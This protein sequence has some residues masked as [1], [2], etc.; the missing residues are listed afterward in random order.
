GKT[1]GRA[2]FPPPPKDGHISPARAGK[3][4]AEE[5][6]NPR[7]LGVD[8]KGK[9]WVCEDDFS[10]KRV[11]IW[12]AATGKLIEEKFGP[13]YVSTAACMD[14]ADPTRVYCQNVEWKVDLDKG[15]WQPAAIMFEAKS[16]SPYFWPHMVNNIVFTAKNGKQYM[17]AAGIY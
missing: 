5:I 15:T 4:N 2:M 9:L 8:S 13:A 6:I 1:G 14:P 10:P 12:E 17:Q 3:W 7:G 11:S 16:D